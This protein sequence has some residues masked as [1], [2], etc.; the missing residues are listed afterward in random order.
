MKIIMEQQDAFGWK[1]PIDKEQYF[2]G[3]GI[4]TREILRHLS[5]NQSVFLIGAPRIG[6][7]SLL[8]HLLREDVQ[9]MQGIIP[10]RHIFIHIDFNAPHYQTPNNFWADIIGEVG[11]ILNAQRMREEEPE[12]QIDKKKIEDVTDTA[13]MEQEVTEETKGEKKAVGYSLEE[14][15]VFLE[16]STKKHQVTIV[17]DGFEYL[18]KNNGLGVEFY[19]T[20]KQ[21]V[22]QIQNL[23]YLVVSSK[24]FSQLYQEN[25]NLQAANISG[26][27]TITQLG[28]LKKR[29]A[30]AFLKQENSSSIDMDGRVAEWGYQVT[31]GHPY[32]LQA[33]GH[34]LHS[35]SIM[36]ME[37]LMVCRDEIMSKTIDECS[38]FFMHLL[39]DLSAEEREGLLAI[40]KFKPVGDMIDL[41]ERKS[42]IRDRK[43]QRV[44]SELFDRFL[45]EFWGDLAESKPA[46]IQ[47]Q[48]KQ[49][50][51]LAG[52]AIF[53][54]SIFLGTFAFLSSAL[55]L[56]TF[57]F[58]LG[59]L[60]FLIV[61]MFFKD[62]SYLPQEMV[63]S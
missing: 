38:G 29:E 19:N 50:M 54:F 45:H 32:L 21:L 42:L 23:S 25:D 3:R 10:K 61:V 18:A 17:M 37:Q 36:T 48:F 27:F 46:K 43:T 9:Q 44:F 33:I 26:I 30:M 14:L 31:G 20:L 53:L 15:T 35:A 1:K 24:G 7:T 4:E 59:M 6:K 51:F 2:Y 12:K 62:E 13:S 5:N 16:D 52:L 60:S 41:L 58:G 28:L 40:I 11:L 22:S 56:G 8:L 47:T 34:H 49:K 55:V 63:R 57:L 39:E